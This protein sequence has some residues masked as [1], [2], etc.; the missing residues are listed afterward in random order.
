[1]SHY[2]NE[3]NR[4]KHCCFNNERQIQTVLEARNYITNHFDEEL[5][6]DQL[7]T[8]Q[9]S[10]KFHLLRLFKRYYGITPKQY[11]TEKRLERSKQ[12]LKAGTAV[13]ETC[14]EVGFESPAS[15]CTLFK[16]RFGCSPSAFQKIAI[17]T[18]SKNI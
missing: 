10:S 11:Q 8:L 7:S 2:L 6:L 12:L 18:K 1:M 9:L 4:I 16:A 15:F 17:F 14:Y 3:I 5:K 13:A